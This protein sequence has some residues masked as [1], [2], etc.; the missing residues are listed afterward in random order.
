MNTC[1][2]KTETNNRTPDEISKAQLACRRVPIFDGKE[3]KKWNEFV[4]C[5]VDVFETLVSLSPQLW[6]DGEEVAGYD[7]EDEGC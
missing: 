3:V 5:R 7:G 2:Y 1:E 4:S 6:D